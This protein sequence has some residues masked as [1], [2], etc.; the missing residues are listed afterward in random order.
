MYRQI[1]I[2]ITENHM[3]EVYTPFNQYNNK[4][5]AADRNIVFAM[6][7]GHKVIQHNTTYSLDGAYPHRL[8]PLL[9]R[10][11]KWASTRWH[12]FIHQASKIRKEH[13]VAR[14][15]TTTAMA[16]TG[17]KKK[18]ILNEGKST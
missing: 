10:A 8:Q 7:S 2:G 18:V 1:A 4:S 12:E 15:P 14:S 3:Q 17:V 11:Y 5:P 16:S 13:E 6:Q 9:L